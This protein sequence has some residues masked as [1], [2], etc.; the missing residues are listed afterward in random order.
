MVCFEQGYIDMV[1]VRGLMSA[2]GFC[3]E[4]TRAAVGM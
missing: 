3:Y 4:E 1:L 2:P